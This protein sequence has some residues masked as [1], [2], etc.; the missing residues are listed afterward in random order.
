MPCRGFDRKDATAAI[1][2]GANLIL[3]SFMYIAESSLHM[4]SPDS[5]CRMWDKDANGYATGEGFAALWLRP[6]SRALRDREEI[7]GIIRVTGVNLDGR[8]KGIYHAQCGNPDH[9]SESGAWSPSDRSSWFLGNAILEALERDPRVKTI[10][11]IVVRTEHTGRLSQSRKGGL[12]C[13]QPSGGVTRPGRGRKPAVTIISQ[14]H[15]LLGGTWS[16]S[17]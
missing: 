5:R 8:T 16:L 7:E 13:R 10:H 11:C 6:L 4:L 3:D 12:L 2:A 9:K 1:F 14:H 15:H 17:E